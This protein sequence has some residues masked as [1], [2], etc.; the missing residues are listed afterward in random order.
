MRRSLLDPRP[1]RGLGEDIL[2]TDPLTPDGSQKK[3]DRSFGDPAM[4]RR[5]E[6]RLPVSFPVKVRPDR[7]EEDEEGPWA[8]LET[9]D[10][11]AGGCR[12]NDPLNILGPGLLVKAR[13]DLGDKTP[14]IRCRMQILD[15]RPSPTNERAWG[16]RFLDLE[17]H[18]EVRIRHR[19]NT[20][21]RRLRQRDRRRA[22]A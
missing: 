18:Q 17:Y 16:A 2:N 10:L 15:H 13:L 4:Q 1:Q 7:Q 5:K 19:L 20:E 6:Y 12:L 3:V 9:L 22:A 8:H 11:S 14:T 21:C